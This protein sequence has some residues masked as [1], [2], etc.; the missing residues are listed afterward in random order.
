MGQSKTNQQLRIR[1]SL[2]PRPNLITVILKER[3]QTRMGMPI[4]AKIGTATRSKNTCGG[5]QIP[6][7]DACGVTVTTVPGG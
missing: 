2:L 1:F 4:A 6:N 5:H 7:P 3:L